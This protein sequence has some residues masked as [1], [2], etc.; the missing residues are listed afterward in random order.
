MTIA[1]RSDFY[2]KRRLL[3]ADFLDVRRC[4]V[5]DRYEHK[6]I[7]GYEG[8]YSITSCGLVYSHNTNAFL[9]PRKRHGYL[10]LNLSKEGK[11]KTFPIH[12]LVAEAFI[13]NPHGLATVNH[14]DRN[15]ENNHVDNLEWLSF[16]DNSLHAHGKL[17]LIVN[18]KGVLE[19]FHNIS[20]FCRERGLCPYALRDLRKGKLKKH[21]GYTRFVSYPK[22]V[23]NG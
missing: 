7:E 9:K 8:L 3:F 6:P 21:R 12:R 11:K 5:L 1:A 4:R 13:P 16:A 22:E 14:K 18:P 17:N 10:R 20:E 15:K 2:T 23:I 19:C